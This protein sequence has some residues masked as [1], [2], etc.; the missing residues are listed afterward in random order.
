[1]VSQAGIAALLDT[2]DASGTL[3]GACAGP[4]AAYAA[5]HPLTHNGFLSLEA[6]DYEW[7]HEFITRHTERLAG[8]K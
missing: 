7:W 3:S 5:A 4:M 6:L 8:G 1:V 2:L